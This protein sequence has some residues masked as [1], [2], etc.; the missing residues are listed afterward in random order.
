MAETAHSSFIPYRESISIFLTIRAIRS[1]LRQHFGV[2]RV[3]E[4][5]ILE[6]RGEAEQILDGAIPSAGRSAAPRQRVCV[7]RPRTGAFLR[8]SNGAAGHGFV[9]RQGIGHSHPRGFED[10]LAHVIVIA[11]A[12]DFL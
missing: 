4:S 5:V 12:G 11:L 10:M 2:R 6:G 8:I 1:S 9:F 7:R 3:E